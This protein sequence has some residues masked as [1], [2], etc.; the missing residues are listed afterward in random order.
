M[1]Q[2]V[3]FLPHARLFCSI[4]WK[5]TVSSMN[6]TGV[7]CPFICSAR[8]K[9]ERK[10]KTGGPYDKDNVVRRMTYGDS[11]VMRK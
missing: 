6:L 3:S 1:K 9:T 4:K 7:R 5:T 8:R 2:N 11:H 10:R